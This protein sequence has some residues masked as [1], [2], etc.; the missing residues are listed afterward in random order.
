M[1]SP[2]TRVC[3][4]GREERKLFF[5]GQASFRLLGSSDPQQAL[6]YLGY[7]DT[8]SGGP[9]GSP[10][11]F[12]GCPSSQ[13]LQRETGS[14]GRGQQPITYPTALGICTWSNQSPLNKQLT[15]PLL[16]PPLPALPSNSRKEV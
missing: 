5:T 4:N 8:G 1:S 2:V 14:R 10:L 16:P 15:Q 12:S 6:T 3:L 11:F 7:T 13:A 9:P